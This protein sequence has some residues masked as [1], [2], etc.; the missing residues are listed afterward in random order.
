MRLLESALERAD[1]DLARPRRRA[2]LA[3]LRHAY[4]GETACQPAYA[5]QDCANSPQ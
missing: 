2:L 5:M 4:S 1:R 3:D